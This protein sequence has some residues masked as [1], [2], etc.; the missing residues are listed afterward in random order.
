MH[1]GVYLFPGLDDLC[2]CYESGPWQNY[3]QSLQLPK[4]LDS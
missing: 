3:C 4:C 2:D 1:L